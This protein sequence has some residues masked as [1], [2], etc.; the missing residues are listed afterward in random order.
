MVNYVWDTLAEK[1]RHAAGDRRVLV[2]AL[3]MAVLAL[4]AACGGDGGGGGAT[5]GAETPSAETLAAETPGAQEQLSA[6]VVSSDL[7]VGSNRFSLGLLTQ[8]NELVT[9]AQVTLGFFKLDGDQ[10]E[11]KSEAEAKTVVVERSYTDVHED[12][13]VDSHEAGDIAV[14]VATV[15][16]DEAGDWGVTVN[17]TRNG[18]AFAPAAAAFRFL[19]ESR[20]V[21]VGEPAPRS[22]QPTLADV[23]DISEIDTSSPPIPQMHDTTIADAVTSGKPTVL[24]FATPEFCQ[25]RICGPTKQIVDDLYGKFK[26]QAVFIHVEP[27]ELEQLRSGEAFVPVPAG[28]EWGLQTEPWVFLVDRDGNVAAKFEAVVSQDE[29]EG[30][31]KR[32]L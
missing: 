2:A 20:T 30:A 28:E 22:V 5:P 26:D 25:S 7:A 18:D 11:I 1:L 29:V 19:E 16:F 21:A 4:A 23:A 8:D 24:V 9:D 31:L 15:E 3:V 32:I 10:A 27:F 12:G 14:Y 13:S 6:V 17:G